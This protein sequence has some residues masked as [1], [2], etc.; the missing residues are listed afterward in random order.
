MSSIFF[1]H[2]QHSTLLKT[3]CVI[4][5]CC[6]SLSLA[7]QTRRVHGNIK[8]ETGETLPGVVVQV[9]GSKIYAST[10]YDGNYSLDL[11]E[12]STTLVINSLGYDVQ[13]I[14]VGNNNTIDVKLLQSATELEGVYVTSYGTRRINTDAG[15]VT[16]LKA[17]ELKQPVAN[18][19]Q[20]L[21]GQSAGVYS[22]ATSGKPGAAAETFIRGVTSI[23]S[24]S[25]PLYVVDGIIISAAQ[26]SSINA[27]DIESITT[28]KDA[29]STALYGSRAS[30][31]VILVTT[32]SG[33][34]GDARITFTAE[35]GFSKH[36]KEKYGMMNSAEKLALELDAGYIDENQYN[37]RIKYNYN[38]FD[39]Y[40]VDTWSQRYNLEI[41]GGNERM[42]YYI[43]GG[44]LDQPGI[45]ENTGFKRYSIRSNITADVKKWLK[46]GNNFSVGY[47]ATQDSPNEGSGSST[48]NLVFAA[49]TTNPYERLYNDDGSYTHH[50]LTYPQNANPL[51]QATLSS[52]S[53][54]S[55]SVRNNAFLE[56]KFTDDLKFKSSLGV[57]WVYA[58]GQGWYSP[59]S[60]IAVNDNGIADRSSGKS[61]FISQT[62]TL[63]YSKQFDDKHNLTLG[64]VGEVFTD[65]NSTFSVAVKNVAHSMLTE[66]SQY[67][68]IYP[69]GWGSSSGKSHTL[70]GLLFANYDY[71]GKYFLEGSLRSDGD[72]RF[73][74]GNKWGTFWSVGAGWNIHREAFMSDLTWLSRLKLRLSA[75]SVGNSAVPSTA[76]WGLYT[77]G[78]TYNGEAGGMQGTI[79]NEDLTWE[80]TKSYNFGLDAGVFNG[81]IRMTVELYRKNVTDMLMS[82][83]L[84]ST[85]SV[86]SMWQ[87]VGSM[88]NQGFEATLGVDIVRSRSYYVSV[89]ANIG[90]NKNEI[91][92]LYPGIPDDGLYVEA[93]GTVQQIGYPVGTFKQVMW[94]GVNPMNGS[95]MWYTAN[96]EV[97]QS[98]PSSDVVIM[99]GKSHFPNKSAG[100]TLK[101]G[102]K[103]LSVDAL[104]TGMWDI[105]ALNNNLFFVEYSAGTFAG[106]MNQTK[107]SGNYWKKPGDYVEYAALGTEAKVDSRSIEN[108]SFFRLKN[109]TV[110]YAFSEAAMKKTKLIQ[111]LRFY[112]GAQNLFTLTNYT[113]FDPEFA[114][115][116]EMSRYPASTTITFG[117]QITF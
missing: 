6:Y 53:S 75:G 89:D 91:T 103:G 9:K 4:A 116:T 31:G 41:Q 93:A 7:A 45:V 81:R 30:N 22:M 117:T 21:Q 39:E 90:I 85:L 68:T 48:A 84:S 46:V 78:S 72:S 112:V 37:E 17:D 11:P 63:T 79:P 83:P 34:Q 105:Y 95:P 51:Y 60:L 25:A 76:V 61:T 66:L 64:A 18:A 110:T 38:Q 65:D 77:L 32:K 109:I 20:M 8:D 69:N 94:A 73:G 15:A 42:L 113:G 10:D 14:L 58:L 24:S 104:F 49:L 44:F 47:T 100:F 26:F 33:R 28:L 40:F 13:E 62:N 2:K 19:T 115:N 55:F 74:N 86:G 108:H 88:Y 87:N 107:R 96:G 106:V 35:G 67:T 70:S 98:Y 99:E 56:F 59:E 50:L 102:Y 80:T 36:I 43:S 3:L 29:A 5:L 111:G 97:V 57:E 101:A 27:G 16:T 1:L 71:D 54:S 114:V 92:E 52:K 12:G 23:N 82:V